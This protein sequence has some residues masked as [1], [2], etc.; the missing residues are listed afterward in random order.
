M[1][2]IVKVLVTA[3]IVLASLF[4]FARFSP[5]IPVSSIVNQKDSY[6]TV[7]GQGKVTVVPDTGVAQLGINLTRPTVKSAQTELNTTMD[8][9][10]KAVK[11]LGV[12]DK[13]I[14][15]THYSIN[16]TYDYNNGQ[17]RITGYMV[18]TNISVTVKDLSKINEVVDAATANGANTVG[19]IMFTVDEKRQKELVQEAREEAIKEAKAK[20]ESL[21][22]AAGITLGRIVNV[23]EAG[24]P[25]PVMPMN[26]ALNK[27]ADGRG[28]AAET[29]VQP[30]STDVVSHVTLSYE[31]R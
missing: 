20:A 23:N 17:N 30:G 1:S 8:K 18:S 29:S 14:Q 11:A 3:G 10:V 5:G 28:G 26:F 7:S 13:D 21:A 9:V 4:I 27:A 6:F 15:T 12:E 16:P 2:W 25:D 19:G 22:K 31:T 24:A